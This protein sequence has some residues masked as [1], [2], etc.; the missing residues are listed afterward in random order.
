MEKKKAFYI[1]ESKN[2]KDIIERYGINNYFI[3]DKKEKY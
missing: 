1:K 2:K 3:N